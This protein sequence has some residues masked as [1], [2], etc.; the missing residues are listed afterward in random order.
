MSTTLVQIP[1]RIGKH[2]VLIAANVVKNELSLLLNKPSLKK[3]GA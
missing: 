1:S 3:D 2:D